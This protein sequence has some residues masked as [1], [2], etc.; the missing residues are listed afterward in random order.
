MLVI[1]PH[2]LDLPPKGSCKI[3]DIYAIT[4]WMVRTNPT[5]GS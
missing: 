5:G 4:K 2:P 3:L 1:K